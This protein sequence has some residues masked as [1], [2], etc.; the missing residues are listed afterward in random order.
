[1][2]KLLLIV[3]CIPISLVLFSQNRVLT[4]KENLNKGIRSHRNFSESQANVQYHFIESTHKEF[5]LSPNEQDIGTTFYDLQANRMLQNRVYRYEDGSI[6][7]VWTR[8]IQSPPDFPDRG[9][10]Y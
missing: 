10:G 4:P 1:M 9:T 8:G 5:T 2:N 7:A 6:G 3:F